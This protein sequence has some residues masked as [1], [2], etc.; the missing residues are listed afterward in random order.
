MMDVYCNIA[1]LALEYTHINF[2]FVTTKFNE[3]RNIKMK[4]LKRRY[5][6]H[7]IW[8]KFEHSD[9]SSRVTYNSSGTYARQ[10]YHLIIARHISKTVVYQ[11]RMYLIKA[12]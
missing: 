12:I 3:I 6:L 9:I 4:C 8:S 5:Y 1:V 11:K 2:G 7:I 10:K